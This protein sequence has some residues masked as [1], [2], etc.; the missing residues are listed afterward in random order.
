MLWIN[1]ENLRRIRLSYQNLKMEMRLKVL[2]VVFFISRPVSVSSWENSQTWRS[3]EPK[4][5]A[6]DGDFVGCFSQSCL[7]SDYNLQ[8]TVHMTPDLCTNSCKARRFPY[9]AVFNFTECSCACELTCSSQDRDWDHGRCG[10]PCKQDQDR[11]CGGFIAADVYKVYLHSS[12]NIECN[13]IIPTDHEPEKDFEY[14]GCYAQS[15]MEFDY[16]FNTTDFE[17]DP[18]S[19]SGACR[20]GGFP[21]ASLYNRSLCSCSCTHACTNFV[22]PEE[23]C[24]LPCPGDSFK[25]CGGF[26]SVSVYRVKTVNTSYTPCSKPDSLLT[27]KSERKRNVAIYTIVTSIIVIAFIMLILY[28]WRKRTIKSPVSKGKSS[29]YSNLKVRYWVHYPKKGNRCDIQHNA[30]SRQ[31][32]VST[33]IYRELEPTSS[34]QV[35][36]APPSVERN[37]FPGEIRSELKW[38]AEGPNQINYESVDTYQYPDHI[39]DSGSN[40][41]DIDGPLTGNEYDYVGL[42]F[43]DMQT[44]HSLTSENQVRKNMLPMVPTYDTSM[45]HLALIHSSDLKEE[46][47]HRESDNIQNSEQYGAVGNPVNLSETLEDATSNLCNDFP[48]TS[49]EVFYQEPCRVDEIVK[50]DRSEA[51]EEIIELNQD[52]ATSN[53][54]FD[55]R[56]FQNGTSDQTGNQSTKTEHDG[57]VS[58]FPLHSDIH[59]YDIRIKTSLNP[60][61][62][63]APCDNRQSS[64]PLPIQQL[65][66]NKKHSVD[67]ER[68]EC[69]G[70]AAK[71]FCPEVHHVQTPIARGSKKSISGS[72]KP[73]KPP[74]PP[75][76]DRKA[77]ADTKGSM[78]DISPECFYSEAHYGLTSIASL[79]KHERQ[80]DSL[81]SSPVVSQSGEDGYLIPKSPEAAIKY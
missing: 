59:M 54:Q 23:Y 4:R 24:G 57:H 52:E 64:K 58:E 48:K 2:L 25:A 67:D 38:T 30:V 61:Q 79:L 71:E 20:E 51:P 50:N 19:C 44:E 16:T 8:S 22:L 18:S 39:I 49:R 81:E 36:Q 72:G 34:G 74:P 6:K 32:Q 65:S 76:R 45:N 28:V 77:T 55:V 43:K 46:S 69:S 75:K 29:R 40:T 15:C 42:N 70:I 7:I 17:N 78:P 11:F 26:T 62:T 56:S 3:E 35:G 33:S 1:D 27:D 60:D 14:K 13:R 9:A 37:D 10:L 41:E 21:V 73:P 53:S 80:H 31:D 66:T 47:N 68:Q 63:V 12:P 5:Y